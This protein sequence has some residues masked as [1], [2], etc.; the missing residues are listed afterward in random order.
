MSPFDALRQS[1]QQVGDPR[2]QEELLGRIGEVQRD[3][4]TQ[5]TEIDAMRVRLNGSGARSRPMPDFVYD[6]PV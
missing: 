4:V 3:F 1:A 2:L 5:R 6:P